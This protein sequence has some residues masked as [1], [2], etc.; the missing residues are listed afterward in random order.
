MLHELHHALVVGTVLQHAGIAVNA[1]DERI[2]ITFLIFN[3]IQIGDALKTALKSLVIKMQPVWAD[4]TAKKFQTVRAWLVVELAVVQPNAF[5]GKTFPKLRNKRKCIFM[6][7]LRHRHDNVIDKADGTDSARL[8]K[9]FDVVIDI[10]THRR[11]PQQ[12][13]DGRANT[14]RLGKY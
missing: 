4:M 5:G 12:P 7:M 10:Q 1:T 3:L 13:A 14:F 6:Q 9:P 8:V 11:L 2:Y